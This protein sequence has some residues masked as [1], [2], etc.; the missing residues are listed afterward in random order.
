[1]ITEA[2]EGAEIIAR[3]I[4]QVVIAKNMTQEGM[5]LALEVNRVTTLEGM[6][7]GPNLVREATHHPQELIITVAVA[8]Q[9]A[10]LPLLLIR[11]MPAKNAK[12][13][14]Q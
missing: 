14:F 1:M 12:R 13:S 10:V 8:V 3:V 9:E 7:L 4:H 5:I 6:N 2:V 11:D